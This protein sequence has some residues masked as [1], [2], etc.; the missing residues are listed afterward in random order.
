M[1]NLADTEGRISQWTYV[2]LWFS[3]VKKKCVKAIEAGEI[4]KVVHYCK[5]LVKDTWLHIL[6]VFV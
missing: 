2:H 3:L 1:L 6:F 5:L 4:A